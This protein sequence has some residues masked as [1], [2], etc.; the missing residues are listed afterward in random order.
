MINLTFLGT[1]A[2]TPS[3]KKNHTAILLNYQGENILIDCGEGTQRQFRYA[4]LNPGKIT[5]I[6]ISHW[7]ADHVLGIPGLIST[8]SLS[9][10]NKT[11]Y[12]YGPKEIETK[13]KNIIRDF[14]L[15][16]EYKIQISEAKGKFI[17][18]K[19]F[20]IESKPMIH[21]TPC[22]AYAFVK[23]EQIKIDKSKL[24]KSKIPQGP[25]LKEL[26]KG[27]DIQYNGKKYLAK[28][29]TY[30]EKQ[31]KI[32]IILD[33][34]FNEKM[35][36]FAKD[37]EILIC[38]STFLENTEKDFAKKHLHMTAKQ[39]ARVAKKSKTKKLFLIHISQRYENKSKEI[40]NEAKK[41]FPNTIIAKD[42]D[43]FAI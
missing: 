15:K 39:A 32:T 10:Y 26:K 38:E 3:I 12:I 16:I 19:D 8:L 30:I 22:N 42:L 5:R 24:K 25:I 6:L 14:N 33:S 36:S 37:S 29:L 41:I 11:L 4:K 43:E 17:E 18:T 28:N 34:L 20:F 2:H 9:G 23:K 21:K 13:I 27:K 7:H 35:I 1:S 40:L 31:K